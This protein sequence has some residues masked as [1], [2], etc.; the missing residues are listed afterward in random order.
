MR[1]L[2][3]LLATAI[4]TMSTKATA[5]TFESIEA[6]ARGQTVYFNAWGGSTQ[7]NDYLNWVGDEVEARFEVTLEHVKLTDTA[8]AVARVLAEKTAG[9]ES[10][11]SIDLIWINGENFRSMKEAELL[12]G[13]F[14]H[15]LPNF[16]LVDTKGKPT[17]L[18]DFTVP[19]DGLESPWGMAQFVLIHDT[20]IVEQPPQDI[21][22]ILAHAE[23][24]PGRV[25]Y[26]HVS[27]F[28]GT[29]FVK[30]VLVERLG[31]QID[32]AEPPPGDTKTLLEP[33][34]SYLDA[35]HDVAWRGGDSFP[36][37]GPAM[38]QLFEDGEIDLTMAFNPA[39][40]S[41]LVIE[42][43]FPE[44][45]RSYTLA[46]GTIANTHFVAIP[47]N[48]AHK[49]GAKVVANFLLSP[50]AQARKQDAQYWGDFTVLDLAALTPEDRAL[51][52]ALERHPTT[53]APEDMAAALPEPHPEWVNVIEQAWT[54]RYQR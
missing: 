24:N 35:L 49:A 48:A 26:P 15:E 44:T 33:V 38:H 51:F 53:P 42:G 4:A 30:Q 17:T 25:T 41:S 46:N 34:F 37:S 7:I 29:T 20:A 11:G 3:V 2:F 43:R 13:P 39:E 28:I 16:A 22:A 5:D 6:E 27:D 9:R 36:P 31:D 47:F 18:V 32:L 1:L 52:D 10:G 21:D 19:T 45:T 8:D 23:A 40:A 14:T 50:E 54:E 12:H